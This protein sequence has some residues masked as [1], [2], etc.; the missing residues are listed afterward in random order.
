M[1]NPEFLFSPAFQRSHCLDSHSIETGV[2]TRETGCIH[3]T[4]GPLT[5]YFL[6]ILLA[7]HINRAVYY[8]FFLIPNGRFRLHFL[9][10]CK[11]KSTSFRL[12][13]LFSHIR[14]SAQLAAFELLF[15]IAAGCLLGC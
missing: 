2:A 7:Q 9:D 3:H 10:L 5:L 4:S 1:H 13:L 12:V 15:I 8:Q 6:W 14:F 11:R